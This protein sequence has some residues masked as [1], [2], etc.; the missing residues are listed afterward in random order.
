MSGTVSRRSAPPGPVGS[1]FMLRRPSRSIRATIPLFGR[2]AIRL[3][4]PARW[5]ARRRSHGTMASVGRGDRAGRF[6]LRDP[7]S[8]GGDHVREP[9]ID[10]LQPVQRRAAE[11]R[12][13]A[14]LE[15]RPRATSARAGV[16]PVAAAR[17]GGPGSL[18]RVHRR[19]PRRAHGP[20]SGPRRRH[21]LLP[22]SGQRRGAPALDAGRRDGGLRQAH[23][24]PAAGH[25]DL[26]GP[27][28]REQPADR[29]PGGPGLRG[30]ERLLQDRQHRQTGARP[31]R[32]RQGAARYRSSRRAIPSPRPACSTR[33]TRR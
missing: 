6:R 15:R 2:R 28:R 10:R 18:Q 12:R 11:D 14:L 8:S 33:R 13:D 5:R 1:W 24:L 26:P 29:D 16:L 4:G 32:G 3:R 22:D 9:G 31:G 7:A 27:A 20:G 21:G 17:G 23:G 25:R 19:R 30:A